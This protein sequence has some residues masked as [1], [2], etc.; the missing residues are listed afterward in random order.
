MKT[1]YFTKSAA[2]MWLVLLLPLLSKAQ[3]V[4]T[5]GDLAF[6]Q[7]NADGTDNFAFVTL[8]DIDANTVIYFSDNEPSSTSISGGEGT[9]EWTAPVGGVSCG[10]VI[11]ITTTP[12]AT[13]GTVSETNDLNFSGSGDGL[14]AYQNASN[15]RTFIAAIGNDGS[16]N[17]I[18]SSREGNIV[19]TGL[20]VGVDAL[21]LAEI[22]NAIYNGTLFSGSASDLL[23]AIND[24]LNWTG[25]NS[26]QETFSGTFQ[27]ASCVGG[28][29]DNDVE[30]LTP[31]VQ[32]STQTI[33]TEDVS[34][35]A[36][37]ENVFRFGIE[38]LASGDGLPTHVTR[39]RIVPGA[40]N[41]AIWSTH[42]AGVFLQDANGNVAIANTLINDN[43]IVLTLANGDLTVADGDAIEV[44]LS[45][46]LQ[47]TNIV[48]GSVLQFMIPATG[49]GFD[50]DN[51]GS[52]FV[53]TFDEGDISS[54]STT[55]DVEASE[56][57]FV[58]QPTDVNALDVMSPAMELAFTDA[59]G[60]VDADYAGGFGDVE[61][62][63]TG[64]FDASATTTVTA[65]N[66]VVT[67][68]NLIFDAAGM[69]V[70]IIAEELGAALGGAT[71][72]SNTFTVSAAIVNNATALV[73]IPTTAQ[74]DFSWV[75]PAQ[76]DEM[77]V[78][79]KATSAVTNVPT[80]DG[81]AYT[82]NAAF[83]SGT[84]LGSNEFVVYKGTGNQVS[85]TGLTDG[86]TYHFTV[87]TRRGNFWSTGVSTSEDAGIPVGPQVIAY[88]G[89]E[90]LGNEWPTTFSTPA[91]NTGSDI[92]DYS[93]SVGTGSSN[94]ITSAA[95]GT[96]FWGARDVQGNCGTAAGETIS[97][98]A[99]NVS[100]YTNLSLSFQYYTFGYD[101]GDYI[102]Y[103]LTVDGVSQPEVTLLPNT[104]AWTDVNISIGTASTVQLDIL[105]DQNG[106]GDWGGIDD[107][108]LIGEVATANP[109]NVI[110]TSN[111]DQE[112]TLTWDSPSISDAIV[113]VA[114]EGQA[115][116]TAPSGDGSTYTSD[117]DFAIGTDIGSNE[118]IVYNGIGNSEDMG[119]FAHGVTY[120]FTVYNRVGTNW[121]TGVETT[122]TL[123]IQAGDIV[124]NEVHYNPNP[125]ADNTH[126]F[127]EVYNSAVYP[128]NLYNWT[129]N[130]GAANVLPNTRMEGDEYV[131]FAQTGTTYSGAGYQV[132]ETSN[133]NLVNSGESVQLLDATGAMVDELTYGVSSGW[134]NGADG[135]GFSLE[136]NHYTLDN[137]NGHN[138]H[139]SFAD[140]GTPGEVNAVVLV[141]V[142]E[143][144]DVTN[145]AHW[146][147]AG[148]TTNALPGENSIIIV[149]EGHTLTLT[150]NVNVKDIY[151]DGSLVVSSGTTTARHIYV[152]STGAVSSTGSLNFVAIFNW[153]GN[154]IVLGGSVV[155]TQGGTAMISKESVVILS[156][157]ELGNGTTLELDNAELIFAED[158]SLS[159]QEG[160]VADANF[161]FAEENTQYVFKANQWVSTSTLAEEAKRNEVKFI[162]FDENWMISSVS[163]IVSIDVFDIQGRVVYQSGAMNT[164]TWNSKRIGLDVMFVRVTLS[165]GSVEVIKAY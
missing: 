163:T 34:D 139:A 44:T 146:M 147:I 125:D 116:I 95:V 23:L 32:V 106:T 42:V 66:G 124:I 5:A 132:I 130:N 19:G 75:N 50:S 85:V 68:D 40:S 127:V 120:Y 149:A 77:L 21:G 67:F 33:T 145:A 53:V 69:G 118:Y 74:I 55:I 71:V 150:S 160:V 59:F 35:P 131:V 100:T 8:T 138:W 7:Y 60:N 80:G 133:G 87:Y 27:V 26:S 155:A 105:I 129:L 22:D 114:R 15:P 17:V 18:N 164:N 144:P 89:F 61:L 76:L 43:E 115:T 51:S 81:A 63:T 31:D 48:D 79:A 24:P 1:G 13:L 29:N 91:C 99:M 46:Y 62:T 90:Q 39:I 20:T 25:N 121:S 98:S 16:G 72:V 117:P 113:V 58:Q 37:A 88:Q 10:T 78:V 49:H 126:E 30:V 112:I 64:S 157:F 102:K 96:Y 107:I 9:I 86:V 94:D 161:S 137:T 52:G 128:I 41:T 141:S 110:A 162:S 93:T 2:F 143:N 28:N 57:V 108:E 84:D 134:A 101:N 109:T 154:P 6:V 111:G 38:D 73:T 119:D 140:G 158:A 12:S 47:T 135:L 104:Q 11:T 153:S 148:T 165:N 97:L 3:S 45:L 56:L 123:P 151:V 82:A 103:T 4:L 65:I 70:E 83:G 92:W 122:Y 14:W 54:N 159:V 152:R 136:L 36:D 142:V 156:S